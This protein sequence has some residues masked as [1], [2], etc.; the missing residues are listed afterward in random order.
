MEAKNGYASKVFFF[1]VPILRLQVNLCYLDN[2]AC[3]I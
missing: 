2:K 1:S 3:L